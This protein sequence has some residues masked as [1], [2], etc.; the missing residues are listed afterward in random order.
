MDK[1]V[2][3]SFQAPCATSNRA[4]T[5]FSRRLSL[6]VISYGVVAGLTTT[7]LGAFVASGVTGPAKTLLWIFVTGVLAVGA[8]GLADPAVVSLIRRYYSERLRRTRGTR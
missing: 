3:T 8:V 4:E 7:A 1:K 5:R 2:E 6:H